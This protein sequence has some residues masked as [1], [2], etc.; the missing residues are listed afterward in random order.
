MQTVTRLNRVEKQILEALDKLATEKCLLEVLA[1]R[2]IWD[3]GIERLFQGVFLWA[4]NSFS[5][6]YYLAPELCKRDYLVFPHEPSVNAVV[7]KT[8][9]TCDPVFLRHAAGVIEIKDTCNSEKKLKEDFDKLKK[10]GISTTQEQMEA[11]FLYEMVLLREWERKQLNSNWLEQSVDQWFNT[12]LR[13]D[14]GVQRVGEKA[15]LLFEHRVPRSSPG[16][17]TYLAVLVVR[18]PA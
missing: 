14:P 17:W 5:P 10:A 18:V 7:E 13:I 11:G 4:F 12:L 2:T 6:Y 15:K 16:I 8:K 3:G 9:N 1:E